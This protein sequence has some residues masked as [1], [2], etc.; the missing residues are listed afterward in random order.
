M[1]NFTAKLKGCLPVITLKY[2]LASRYFPFFSAA[3]MLVL[4]CLA[5]DIVMIYY[6]VA[7]LISMLLLLDDL[8]PVI[9]HLLFFNVLAS[10]ENTTMIDP[11]TQEGGSD[12]FFSPVIIGLIIVAAVFLTAALIYRFALTFRRGT[13]K[14]N[15]IFWGL[16]ALSAALLLNGTAAE[17]YTFLNFCYG[18]MLAFA[19]LGMYVL[20]SGNVRLNEE[21]FIKIGFGFVAFSLLLIGEIFILYLQIMPEFMQFISGEL[22]YDR[23]KEYINFGWGIWNNAAL[24]F[25]VCIPPVFLLASKYKNGWLLILFATLVA[26]CGALTWSR[27]GLIGIAV[28]YPAS[29]VAVMIK[30]KRRMLNVAAV[31]AVALVVGVAALSRLDLIKGLF[32]GMSDNLVGDDGSYDGNGR[33]SLIEA[34]FDYFLANPVF[35][36]GFFIDFESYGATDFAQISL[37]PMM[38]HNTFAELLAAAGLA[39]IITYC[40]HRV[41]TVA[42][43]FARPSA[44]KFFTGVSIAALLAMCLFDNHIFYI[45]PTIMYSGLLVFTCEKQKEK[46]G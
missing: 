29:A 1:K 42:A 24:L 32:G 46:V 11:V 7:V 15:G 12:Y 14:P 28:A 36:S 17:G 25:A 10:R 37:I 33:L 23:F 18:F 30:G 16:C 44:D 41:Q 20:I 3:V 2:I 26:A 31:C 38:A 22:I 45:V 34:A 39:G 9:G 21:N 43:F 35:G 8:T 6:V 4:T 13:F 19:F 5:L 40:V 27:Q